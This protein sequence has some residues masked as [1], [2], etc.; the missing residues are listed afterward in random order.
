MYQLFIRPLLFRFDAESVH[1]FTFSLIKILFK[2]PFVPTIFQALYQVENPAL[3]RTVFGLTFKNPVGLA[4]GFDKNAI[5]VDELASMGFGFIEIGTIT[6]KPQLGNDK[7]RL[8]RLLPDEAIINRMGFN[9]DGTLV[10]IE[11]L[12]NR[13]SNIIVGGNIGKNKVTPNQDAVIIKT[14]AVD[15]CLIG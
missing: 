4:A 9:N 10:A 6:P 12:K 5:L 15:D 13:K 2:I 11:R 1:H 14:H 3:E 7:P 8:F